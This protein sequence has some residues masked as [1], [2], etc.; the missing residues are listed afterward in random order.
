MNPSI[1]RLCM[2]LIAVAS[3]NAGAAESRAYE[4]GIR[5]NA[6]YVMFAGK[7]YRWNSSTVCRDPMKNKLTC[8]TLVQVGYA[9]RARVVLSDDKATSIDILDLQQ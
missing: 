6:K 2:I 7:D 1:I 9:N 8:E 5:I 4:G 3:V